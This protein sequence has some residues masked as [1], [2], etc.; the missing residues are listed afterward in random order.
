MLKFKNFQSLTENKFSIAEAYVEP[1]KSLTAKQQSYYQR[2]MDRLPILDNA[3]ANKVIY[4]ADFK[5]GDYAVKIL[6]EKI[7][8]AFK[9][10]VYKEEFK[11][12]NFE[13]DPVSLYSLRSSK[14][15]LKHFSKPELASK[16]PRIVSFLESMVTVHELVDVVKKTYLVK[17]KKPKDAVMPEKGATAGAAHHDFKPMPKLESVKRAKELMTTLTTMVRS[18]YI[19]QFEGV[20]TD[21]VNKIKE[22][23]MTPGDFLRSKDPRVKENIKNFFD[24]SG[25]RKEPMPVR[26]DLSVRIKKVSEDTVNTILESLIHKNTTKLAA[27][28]ERKSTITKSEVGSYNLNGSNLDATMHFEFDDGSKFTMITKTE[29]S[30]SKY[31]KPFARYPSRFTN[32]IK[33]DGSRMKMPSEAKMNKEF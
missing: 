5:D 1:F 14:K 28:F 22:K 25:P 12:N 26:P 31:G 11:A 24:Y 27:I 10:E 7:Y 21:N 32:V 33:A 29:F 9:Y 4:S 19:K 6:A 15:Y 8:D 20:Y 18:E 23:E 13:D 2:L 3:L 17:G 16:Y 30:W